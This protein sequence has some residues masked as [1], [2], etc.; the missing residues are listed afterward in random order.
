MPADFD[1]N[2]AF[3]KVHLQL[4]V[5]RILMKREAIPLG[6]RTVIFWIVLHGTCLYIDTK[7]IYQTNPGLTRMREMDL[8][9][10]AHPHSYE[11]FA[12][13]HPFHAG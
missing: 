11:D 10:F 6:S 1:N 2:P 3:G 7:M 12:A 9:R 4:F 5:S 8:Q 13:L